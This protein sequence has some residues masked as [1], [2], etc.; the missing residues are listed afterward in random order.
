MTR[1]LSTSPPPYDA[2]V[3]DLDG[4]LYLGEEALPGAVGLVKALR[5]RGIPMRFLSNNPTR[6]AAEYVDKL[7]RLG[8]EA[9]PEEVV[10]TVA[11]TCEWLRENYPDAVVF[12]I[13][14][15]P[16]VDALRDAGIRLSE[17]PEEVDIVVASYDRGFTH[18]K[19]Q[20]AFDAIW[21]HKRAFLVST[22]PD[23][24]C[25]FPDGRGEPDCA[26]IVAAIEV[27]TGTKCVAT[28]GK[29][30]PH[31]AQT[32]LAGMGAR[33][34]RTL[35]VGDRLGT[36]IALGHA[37]GMDTALVLTG[38]STLQDVAD[39]SVKSRPTYVI[40]RVG[41][42]LAGNVLAPKASGTISKSE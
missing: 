29:P 32:A 35:M 37:S 31:I 16:L 6:N 9:Q 30:N 15:Q 19:L 41:E 14:E 38:D 17:N 3:F 40:E 18:A 2:Y 5:D 8:F 39:T 23:R 26:P 27:A 24:Y 12:P 20:I 22:N 36:D 33:A 11:A 13:A 4:T 7:R 34:E 10:T 25:P 21:Q 1:S 42:L 28:I